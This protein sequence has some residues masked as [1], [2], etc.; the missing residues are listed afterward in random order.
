MNYMPDWEAVTASRHTV[1]WK[2]TRW[3]RWRL[4]FN[5]LSVLEYTSWENIS[6]VNRLQQTTFDKTWRRGGRFPRSLR[7]HFT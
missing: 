6:K 5:G 2:P 1:F 4:D 7:L 3:Q